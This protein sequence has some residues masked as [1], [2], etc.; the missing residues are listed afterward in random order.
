M[1]RYLLQPCLAMAAMALV[2]GPAPS[3]GTDGPGGAAVTIV[4][5]S[6]SISCP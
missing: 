6:G 1:L 5:D 2:L 3:P 4:Q